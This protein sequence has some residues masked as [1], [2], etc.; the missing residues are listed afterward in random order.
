MAI[1]K[2]I[3]SFLVLIL[4][5]RTLAAGV[6]YSRAADQ[7]SVEVTVYNNNLG[8]VKDCRTIKLPKG[9]GELRFMDV[10]SAVMPVTVHVKSLNASNQFSVLEQNYEYDLISESKLL[11]KFVGKKVK[12]IDINEYK[13]KREEIEAV[14]LSNNDQ[15]PIF[16]INKEIYLGYPGIKVLPEIPENLIAKPTLTWTYKNNTKQ[17]HMLKASYLTSSISWK[18]DY[19]VVLDKN[20]KRS[21]ISC[22]VTIDNESGAAYKNASLKLIAGEVHRV[23]ERPGRIRR[24]KGRIVYAKAAAAPQF[25]E[26]EFFEYHIYK[27]TRKT[28]I[29]DNQTKQV[30]L[31][32]A[33]S[34]RV[35]KELLVYGQQGYYRRSYSDEVIKVPV[36]V[37]VAFKNEKKNNLGMPFP[38]GIIR[39]YKKDHDGSQ[40]FV[41][42]ARIEHNP[43]DEEVRLKV[44]KAFDVLAE[45]VQKDYKRVKKN[46]YES[47]WE[48]KI[49]NH[50]K[51]KVVVG[52]IEPLHGSWKVVENSHDYRKID[53]FRIRFDVKVLKDGEATITYRVRSKW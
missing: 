20:D 52:I 7:T 37:Y 27:L 21:D 8:L 26:K 11:D 46:V 42:E 51:E 25:E 12:I 39:M 16:K 45:R 47:E 44:G 32:N 28:T 33:N 35:K 29:K 31:F 24:K 15:Q 1:F 40:Q 41:G 19:V 43:K 17:T 48:I 53:A 3:L 14:L 23:Y 6:T 2:T 49:R 9:Q 30:S 22:W 13:D 36:H 4:S 50:K 34:V 38:A 18:A 10:A 5:L